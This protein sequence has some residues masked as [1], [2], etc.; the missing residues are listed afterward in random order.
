M[1]LIGLGVAWWI[2]WRPWPL[3]L[4][5]HMD[6]RLE[7]FGPVD[8]ASIGAIRRSGHDTDVTL[9]AHLEYDP[10][11]ITSVQIAGQEKAHD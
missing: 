7:S 8:P 2:L 6:A 4:P 3:K 11:P 1:L 9:S 5:L 10:P